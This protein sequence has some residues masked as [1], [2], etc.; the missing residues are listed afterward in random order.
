MTKLFAAGASVRFNPVLTRSGGMPAEPKA[1]NDNPP[2]LRDHPLLHEALRH[3]AR[4]GLHA[5]QAAC[6][7]AEAAL[8]EDD[9]EGFDRWLAICRLLDRRKADAL[10]R[11]RDRTSETG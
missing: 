3:F 5:A 8:L 7:K 2:P 10:A 6:E 1:A 4:H 9:R 11:R